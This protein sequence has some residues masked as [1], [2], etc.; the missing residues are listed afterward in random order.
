[1]PVLSLL[2]VVTMER[3][4]PRMGIKQT[5]ASLLKLCPDTNDGELEAV[6]H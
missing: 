6:E 3:V 4:S 2:A 1:M 5:T